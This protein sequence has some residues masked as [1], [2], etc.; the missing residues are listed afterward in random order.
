[1]GRCRGVGGFSDASRWGPVPLAGA[2]RPL[3]CREMPPAAQG[4]RILALIS[5]EALL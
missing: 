1:M 5:V 4:L 3:A 2:F